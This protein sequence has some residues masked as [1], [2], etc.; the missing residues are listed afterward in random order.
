MIIK[1]LENSFIFSAKKHNKDELVLIL[2]KE[3]M[4][5]IEE[6]K[7]EIMYVGF[8]EENCI[9]IHVISDNGLIKYMLPFNEEIRNLVIRYD[10][11]HVILGITEDLQFKNV[12]MIFEGFLKTF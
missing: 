5:E 10:L 8:N 12:K 2:Y 6:Y 9:E 4:P 11:D 3:E 1:P 7:G